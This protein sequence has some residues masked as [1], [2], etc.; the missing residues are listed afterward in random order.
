M[1]ALKFADPGDYRRVEQD[2]VLVLQGLRDAIGAHRTR[3]ALTEPV[4]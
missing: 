4:A 3:W 1:L 2:D